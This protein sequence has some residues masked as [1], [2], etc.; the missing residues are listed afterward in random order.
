MKNTELTT[1]ERK[2][3]NFYAEYIAAHQKKPTAREVAAFMGSV[4]PNLG[5][6]YLKQL[7]A[8][9]YLEAVPVMVE[10]L[11][12]TAKGKKAVAATQGAAKDE[13]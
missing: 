1:S 5:A 10:S 2:A 11:A 12:L 8:K 6:L 13:E 4:H 9:G 7:K 3:L